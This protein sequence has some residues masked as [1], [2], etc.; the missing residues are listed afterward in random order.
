M[1]FSWRRFIYFLICSLSFVTIA[2]YY[3]LAA[4]KR[5]D[6]FILAVPL[7]ILI[8]LAVVNGFL[9]EEKRR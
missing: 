4:G 7:L 9:N 1:K 2:H 8:G 6:W 3:I 5:D